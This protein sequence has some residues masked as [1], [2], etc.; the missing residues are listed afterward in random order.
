M[1][2]HMTNEWIQNKIKLYFL[3][4]THIIIHKCSTIQHPN[5]QSDIS[6]YYILLDRKICILKRFILTKYGDSLIWDLQSWVSWIIIMWSMSQGFPSSTSHSLS[7]GMSH[8][9]SSGM[10]HPSSY[11]MNHLFSSSMSHSS[12]SM[13][14]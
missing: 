5:T 2:L 13:I 7:S 8:S 6:K 14:H 3:S 12:S 4:L 1:E 11:I 10:T 9:F